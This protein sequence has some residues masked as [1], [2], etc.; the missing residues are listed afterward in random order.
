MTTVAA[1]FYLH[2]FAAMAGGV[3]IAALAVTARQADLLPKPLTVLGLVVAAASV[4][5]ILAG[6]WILVEAA[7]I[8]VAAGLLARRPALSGV[9]AS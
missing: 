2:G 5:G 4:P 3:L 7:W 9:Y 8:A 1:G 6:M